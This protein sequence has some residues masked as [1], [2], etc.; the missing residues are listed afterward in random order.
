MNMTPESKCVRVFVIVTVLIWGGAFVVT[1]KVATLGIELY[2]TGRLP[3]TVSIWWRLVPCVI[4]AITAVHRILNMSSS[5]RRG[6]SRKKELWTY[7]VLSGLGIVYIAVTFSP[8]NV[9]L[10]TAS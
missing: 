3:Y 1:Q 6:L 8:V 9:L 7:I 2:Q 5:G 4:L 10:E